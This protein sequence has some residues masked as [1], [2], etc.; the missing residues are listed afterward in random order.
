[1]AKV[2]APNKGY[3]GVVAGVSFVNGM[4][5][6]DNRWLLMWFEENGYEV[7][8]DSVWQSKSE[9]TA[10]SQSTKPSNI[11]Q[12]DS[13]QTSGTTQMRQQKKKRS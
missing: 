8:D 3:T 4:G 9:S 6:T 10:M 2:F 13:T 11:S 12:N 1:M 5:E 7:E